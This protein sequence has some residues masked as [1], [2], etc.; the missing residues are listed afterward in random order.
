MIVAWKISLVIALQAVH[1]SFICFLQD[2]KVNCYL[3]TGDCNEPAR[4]G[5]GVGSERRNL[6]IMT[7]NEDLQIMS[8]AQK[9]T[10]K[11]INVMKW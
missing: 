9:E 2:G 10:K 6:V 1:L 8:I 11:H 7:I 3:R 5:E 4:G